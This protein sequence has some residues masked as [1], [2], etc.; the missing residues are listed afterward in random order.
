MDFS[1]DERKAMI[2]AVCQ[3]KQ[4]DEAAA[5]KDWWVT[6][7][8]YALFHTNISEYLLFKGGTSLSKGWNIINRFSEV[9][10]YNLVWTCIS[11]AK[12]QTSASLVG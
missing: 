1:I 10:T 5:E 6:A 7:V 4:I 11:H 12:N 9:A 2:Q 3:T 8:L